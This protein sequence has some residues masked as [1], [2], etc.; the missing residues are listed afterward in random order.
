MRTVSLLIAL[1]LIPDIVAQDAAAGTPA[2]AAWDVVPFQLIDKPFA[3]G[4]VAFH[5]TGCR[6]DFTIAQPATGTGDTDDLVKRQRSVDRATLN[7]RTG[8]WEYWITVD[9]GKL[10]DGP[11]AVQAEAVPLDG[12][13]VTTRLE[14]L[15][16]YANANGTLTPK[17]PV[18]ADCQAGNDETPRRNR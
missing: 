16:L 14:S 10:V 6:V 11:V 1:I 5:E 9:P 18:W 8:V 13:G 2:I 3:V 4:V 7:E 12:A 17:A 15:T